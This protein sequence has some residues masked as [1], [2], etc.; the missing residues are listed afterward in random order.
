VICGHIHWATIREIDGLQY[1]NCGDWV[2]SCTA[3]VEHFDGR[4]SWWWVPAG[5]R[6]ARGGRRRRASGHPIPR[7]RSCRHCHESVR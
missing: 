4:L 7:R 3:I 2:D 6:A 5:P 1:V